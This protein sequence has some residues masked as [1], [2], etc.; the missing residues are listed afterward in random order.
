MFFQKCPIFGQSTSENL[1]YIKSTM[2]KRWGKRFYLTYILANREFRSQS[3]LEWVGGQVTHDSD[4][5]RREDFKNIS[6]VCVRLT[7]KKIY[8]C[9]V[10]IFR[11]FFVVVAK[12]HMRALF[13]RLGAL[14]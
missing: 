12:I 1:P 2:L 11:F 7:V 14:G 6:S 10:S 3:K 4:S 13:F 5:S 8:A 9:K